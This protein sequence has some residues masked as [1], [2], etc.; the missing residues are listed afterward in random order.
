MPTILIDN[1]EIEI[2]AGRRLNGIEAARLAGIEI[3]SLLLAS[4]PVGGGQL[5]HVPGRGRLA[6]SQDR[7]DHHA[8]EALAGLQYVGGRQHGV[9]DQ[10]REGRPGSGDGRR[11]LAAASSDRLPHLRQGRRVRLAGLSLPIRPGR[12]PG[13]SE[14]L[15][16]PAARSGRRNAVRGSLRAVQPLRAIYRRNQRHPRTDVHRPRRPRRDRR[17]ARLSLEQQAFGQRGRSLPGGGAGRQ[18]FSIQAAGVVHE[19]PPRRL[20]RLRHRLLD[21]DRGE[22]G[23]HLSHQAAR[24]SVGQQVVDLQRRPLRLSAR[25]RSAPDHRTAPIAPLSIGRGAATPLPSPFGRGAGGEGTRGVAIFS[26]KPPSP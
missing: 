26:H 19:T 17:C 23:P 25:P 6:R 15:H 20:H 4:G 10:Q 18:G 22:P 13:R 14:P 12:A 7:Q 9:G 24:E 21:L 16:Q 2:P 11:G 3:P 1:R 8:A 5:P